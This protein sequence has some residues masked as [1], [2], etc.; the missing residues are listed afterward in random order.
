MEELDLVFKHHLGRL[1]FDPRLPWYEEN[2]APHD[3]IPASS[4]MLQTI[5]S[6]VPSLLSGGVL[7]I[8]NNAKRY[9]SSGALATDTSAVIQCHVRVALIP[10]EA[11]SSEEAF[12]VYQDEEGFLYRACRRFG[13][14]V[15]RLAAPPAA[16]AI[17]ICDAD[18]VVS[19]GHVVFKHSTW[20]RDDRFFV[21]FYEYTGAVGVVT[22][23]TTDV[24]GVTT[25][26]TTPV[27]PV[28][29]VTPT[30]SDA[31][32]EGAVHHFFTHERFR[33]SL[34]AITTDDIRKGEKT[35]Q[36]ES[37]RQA[38]TD[39]HHQRLDE[40][41]DAGAAVAME[42]QSN[43]A[44]VDARITTLDAS[45]ENRI[46][47][48]TLGSLVETEASMHFN[49]SAFDQQ[50][51]TKTTDDITEGNENLFLKPDFQLSLSQTLPLTWT[52]DDI[53][54]GTHNRYFE[55]ARVVVVAEPVALRAVEQFASR[56]SVG[57]VPGAMDATT[58]HSIAGTVAGELITSAIASQEQVEAAARDAVRSEIP[59]TTDQL[60][61]GTQR[62]YFTEERVADSSTIAMVSAR[63]DDLPNQASAIC[64]NLISQLTIED[65]A[66]APEST[67]HLL[68][69]PEFDSLRSATTDTVAEGSRLYFSEERV[70]GVVS[71]LVQIEDR[72]RTVA[73]QVVGARTLDD[74]PDGATRRLLGREDVTTC[75]TQAID[76]LTLDSL[77]AGELAT[78]FRVQDA[79]T[80]ATLQQTTAL[81]NAQL[82]LHDES[83]SNLQLMYVNQ[84]N[85]LVTQDAK[86]STLEI[87]LAQLT[88]DTRG[89]TS[90]LQHIELLRTQLDELTTDEVMEGNT[91]YFTTQRARDA[92]APLLNTA[93][94][95]ESDGARYFTEE[96]CVVAMSPTVTDHS[97]RID[98][99]TMHAT[100]LRTD[101]DRLQADCLQATED[102]ASTIATLEAEHQ[103]T[104]LQATAGLASVSADITG[105]TDALST[106]STENVIESPSAMYFTAERSLSV[107]R[108]LSERVSELGAQLADSIT[109]RAVESDDRL[110]FN[111]QPLTSALSVV[112]SLEPVSY[113]MVLSLGQTPAE[114]FDDVGFIAQDVLSVQAL[115][116]AVVPGD[117]NTP[118]LLDYH[119]I[120]TYAIAAINELQLSVQTVANVA[121]GALAQTDFD[122][123]FQQ[124]TLN[125]TADQIEP[126]LTRQYA[127]ATPAH[128][129]GILSLEEFRFL[130]SQ[131]TSDDIRQGVLNQY[132]AA[133]PE[134]VFVT[135]TSQVA[136]TTNLYFTNTRCDARVDARLAQITAADITETYS[137]RFLT[138]DNLLRELRFINADAIADGNT[139][140]YFTLANFH[141]LGVTTDNVPESTSAL[142]FTVERARAAIQ[143][144]SADALVGGINNQFTTPASVRGVMAVLNTDDLPEAPGKRYV[145]RSA[146]FELQISVGDILGSETLAVAEDVDRNLS[147]ATLSLATSFNQSLD[148]VSLS[149][150]T[151]FNHSL[152]AASLSLATS[153]DQ[154]LSTATLN[155]A[156]SFDQNLS[157]ATLSLATSFD[158]SLHVASLSLAT[159]F[160]Q[161]L[162]TAT[163]SLA[164]SFD[165][166]LSTASLS[167][168]TSFDQSLDAASL[169][170]ATDLLSVSQRVASNE[171]AH[172][173]ISGQLQILGDAINL[174]ILSLGSGV[175]DTIAN[176]STTDITETAQRRFVSSTAIQEAQVSTDDLQEG[177]NK[178]A[179]A[180]NIRDAF[181]VAN[182]LTT[183]DIFEGAANRFVTK[184]AIIDTTLR[185]DDLESY[186]ATFR[187][188]F[189]AEIASTT[190]DAL[191]EGDTNQY[192]TS[193]RVLTALGGATTDLIAEGTTNRYLSRDG[194]L[195]I[196][197]D[198]T[199]FSDA[200]SVLLTPQNF[201]AAAITSDDLTE[202]AQNKYATTASVK[203]ILTGECDTDE[204]P[205]GT[206]NKYFND[207]RANEWFATKTTDDLA[208]GTTASFFSADALAQTLTLD[209]ITATGLA[210]ADIGAR[211]QTT[212]ITTGELIESTSA[213][214]FTQTRFDHQFA[215]KTTDDLAEGANL[216]HTQNRVDS[217]LRS[218]ATTADGIV[219]VQHAAPT[220]LT[221]AVTMPAQQ[222]LGGVLT[223][224][225]VP[226][227]GRT[228]TTEIPAADGTHVFS[229]LCPGDCTITTTLVSRY[230]E[231]S[232]TFTTEL[233]G[234]PP[235]LQSSRFTTTTTHD[236]LLELTLAGDG[237]FTVEVFVVAGDDDQDLHL[238]PP[239]S[240]NAG[241]VNVPLRTFFA[242]ATVRIT[243]GT[244]ENL[245]TVSMPFSFVLEIPLGLAN[246]YLFHTD[247]NVATDGAGQIFSDF[248]VLLVSPIGTFDANSIR[249]TY[250]NSSVTFCDN[251]HIRFG[252]TSGFLQI[253]RSVGA[254]TTPY[255]SLS[256]TA[257]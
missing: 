80:L 179:S 197:F 221:L 151:S 85:E 148:S 118:F 55:D 209:H 128:A 157:T 192:F 105:I 42:V 94:V 17:E 244:H 46:H 182:N 223:L 120:T 229:D 90:E 184:Q 186:A 175:A 116:H 34:L 64:T 23:T 222:R 183:D 82:E 140:R 8:D 144:I 217:V 28:G 79:N 158:Q 187:S 115:A 215:A 165:Q 96:R 178:F 242:Q 43:K 4:V 126:G 135:D 6:S 113:T 99:V 11:Y 123:E 76:V 234:T 61:E 200:S 101:V 199:D 152:D 127:F 57:D 49:S 9:D 155:L 7:V 66:P 63:I 27:V 14:V 87:S 213:L 37:E 30:T 172:E 150:A 208:M 107:H 39:A 173:T 233:P 111:E 84:G 75:I 204:L 132:I 235:F 3:L 190:S 160:D 129:F 224:T 59:T 211:A 74:L 220:Q 253:S 32:V 156:T 248:D 142:Y 1:G 146:F 12:Y 228:Q 33:T 95:T 136:E 122:H 231:L 44:S 207:Q 56:L 70:R 239:T 71:G 125:L 112:A 106:L 153:F 181:A 134:D 164:T 250:N 81:H 93:N 19:H 214:F 240:M 241:V 170:L 137:R 138:L 168:A 73:E 110:K 174:E 69:K 237:E 201:A 238:L 88:E 210:A 124:A 149:L 194:I 89:H 191:A 98:Q 162:S 114:G 177:H 103:A 29:D 51:A 252:F 72:A 31:L 77:P 26:T 13:V 25:P 92:V 68:T 247:A 100:N 188:S 48:T 65:L 249:S 36:D 24:V 205:E 257:A 195:S 226:R 189:L 254:Q 86:V 243:Q 227:S 139:N 38:V 58:T 230:V 166:N 256:I 5:P 50:L 206:S 78:H 35:R 60:A 52:T 97:Q 119:S 62:L 154:N 141:E 216:Y 130:L 180:S 163:L 102:T 109:L 133:L 104:R 185:P 15:E 218:C 246:D 225:C 212:P 45:I 198:V 121:N 245:H 91:Q 202:G 22:P 117:E 131:I 159:S 219:T 18:Y 41:A 145:S 169:S 196:Q 16:E 232:H 255:L 171:D 251:T 20:S 2:E 193:D 53:A 161:S 176:L 83:L 236:H 21:S 203:S 67:Y 143:N 54:E 40:I 147:T 10:V 167:L 108:D 47:Q